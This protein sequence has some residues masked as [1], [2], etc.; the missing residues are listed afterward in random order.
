MSTPVKLI[1]KTHVRKFA[2]AMAINRGRKFDRVADDFY[3]KCET[4]LKNFIREH[5]HSMPSVGKTI[6]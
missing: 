2:L 1:S 6:R 3:V 4:H 5:V